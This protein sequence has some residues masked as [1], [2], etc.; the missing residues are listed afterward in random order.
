MIEHGLVECTSYGV[1][2]HISPTFGKTKIGSESDA[3]EYLEV[4]YWKHD[5]GL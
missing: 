2:K 5:I 4:R 3:E 1:H